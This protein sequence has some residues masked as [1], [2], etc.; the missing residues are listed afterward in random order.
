VHNVSHLEV[1]IVFVRLQVLTAASMK[2][3]IF[4]D[5]ETCSLV[6]I[7][8]SFRS[9]YCLHYQGAISQKSQNCH[10]SKVYTRSKRKLFHLAICKS[11]ENVSSAS[12]TGLRKAFAFR[13]NQVS[14]GSVIDY[15]FCILPCECR[16]NS[17]YCRFLSHRVPT[18]SHFIFRLDC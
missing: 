5:T 11:L 18:S 14:L 3:P 4:W 1:G 8:R 15:P 2:M 6:E 9:V 12:R 10:S 17:S 13:S 7:Y 16:D